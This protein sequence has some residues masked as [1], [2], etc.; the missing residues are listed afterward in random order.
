MENSYIPG[1]IGTT[2]FEG[3]NITTTLLYPDKPGLGGTLKLLKRNDPNSGSDQD[4]AEALQKLGCDDSSTAET[5]LDLYAEGWINFD[6]EVA[7]MVVRS[8]NN[9]DTES[10]PA[11]NAIQVD[12]VCRVV[13]APA[14]NVPTDIRKRC[15]ELSREAIDSL[16]KGASGVFGVELFVTKEGNTHTPRLHVG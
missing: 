8:S 1:G 13:L 14:R 3:N 9:V 2:E 10:Y 12:S 15:E 16:G 4:I 7:V 6:C 11:V 5:E